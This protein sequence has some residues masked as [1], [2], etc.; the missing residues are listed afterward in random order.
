MRAQRLKL[1]AIALVCLAGLTVGHA[2]VYVAVPTAHPMT[3]A[4]VGAGHHQWIV[5]WQ[6]VPLAVLL[7]VGVYATGSRAVPMGR[8]VER[9]WIASRLL[10]LQSLG[11]IVLETAERAV[12]ADVTALA[13]EPVLLIGL[14]V[15][16]LVALALT[17]ILDLSRAAVSHLRRSSPARPRR[18]APVAAP[19]IE[20]LIVALRPGRGRVGFRAPP[21]TP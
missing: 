12:T 3:A 20:P 10:L 4:L 11:F 21:S 17:A 18:E 8:A 5:P 2:L 6:A 16:A 13:A 1:A 19:A 15:Q 7:A 9:R 14:A